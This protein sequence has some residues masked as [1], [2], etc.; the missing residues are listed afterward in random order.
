MRPSVRTGSRILLILLGAATPAIAA[1]PSTAPELV[2][3]VACRIG[4]DCLIQSYVDHDP[5][6]A[7]TDYLCHGRTY[8]GHDGTD[9]RVDSMDRQ[10]GGVS[11]LAAAAGTV[12]RIRNDVADISIRDPAAPPLAGQDCGNGLVIAHKDGWETQY[13]HM[14]RGSVLVTPG[15]T[16]AAGARLGRVG[17]SGNTEFP[18]LHLTVRHDGQVVDPFADGARPGQCGGGRSLWR[19]STGIAQSYRRGAVLAAGFATGPVSMADATEHGAAQTPKPDRTAP[20]LVAFVQAV[21]LEAGDVQHL[22]LTDPAGAPLAE[23]RAAPL[24]RDKAQ[25]IL[26]AGR[27]RPGTIWPAGLYHARYSVFRNGRVLITRDIEIRL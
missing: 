13:C 16:V 8:Q 25:T 20:A 5:G 26:F 22:V 4:Q 18:H 2:L 9:F 27:R 7:A 6:P 12:L 19:A 11:V 10:R 23:N 3:P 1:A 24:D 21:G 17:L 15:Q 14:A